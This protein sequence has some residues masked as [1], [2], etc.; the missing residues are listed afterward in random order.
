[1]EPHAPPATGPSANY[2]VTLAAPGNAAV[3]G[4]GPDGTPIADA[5]RHQQRRPT[6]VGRRR[7]APVDQIR[8]LRRPDQGPA[9][10]HRTHH[11]HPQRRHR[12]HHRRRRRRPGAGGRPRR[13]RTDQAGTPASRTRRTQPRRLLTAHDRTTQRQRRARRRRHLHRRRMDRARHRARM[14]P[15]LHLGDDQ[16]QRG[17]SHR[18]RHHT[19]AD[20]SRGGHVVGVV[21]PSSRHHRRPPYR[22]RRR[23]P[24]RRPRS[25]PGIRVCRQLDRRLRNHRSFLGRRHRWRCAHPRGSAGRR[26]AGGARR[27]VRH[28]SRA[29]R[30]RPGQ[31]GRTPRRPRG[32][33]LDRTWGRSPGRATT[34]PSPPTSSRR[35]NRHRS[36]GRVHC[37]RTDRRSL[38]RGP[39]PMATTPSAGRSP[40]PGPDG[41][42][43]RADFGWTAPPEIARKRGGGSGRGRVSCRRCR[44]GGPRRQRWVRLG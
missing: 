4:F 33:R 18:R 26:T 2:E 24:H 37:R 5:R 16:R 7:P 15:E 35:K 39:H 20:G 36:R 38:A 19:G 40:S 8:P 30:R 25:R 11:H 32:P 43:L 44:R 42:R 3:R 10:L 34:S 23:Q 17:I 27:V 21:H 9:H 1:M 31:G 14:R 12:P 6:G 28:L 13:V 29:R 41:R 22:Q